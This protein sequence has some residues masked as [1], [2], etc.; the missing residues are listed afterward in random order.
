VSTVYGNPH[1]YAASH[2]PDDELEL[3]GRA[4]NGIGYENFHANPHRRAWLGRVIGDRWH[5]GA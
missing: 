4:A 1:V 3:G 5:Y 2:V